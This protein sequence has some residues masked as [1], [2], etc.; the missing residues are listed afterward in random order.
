MTDKQGLRFAVWLMECLAGAASFKLGGW[1]GVALYLGF[2][3]WL[4]HKII[5]AKEEIMELIAKEKP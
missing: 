4:A 3:A 2:G 1:W 5:V